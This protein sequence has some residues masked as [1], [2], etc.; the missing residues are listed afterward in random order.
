MDDIDRMLLMAK[1]DGLHMRQLQMLMALREPH[2][3][4]ELARILEIGS[5][6]VKAS[7]DPISMYVKITEVEHKRRMPWKIYSLN[8]KGLRYVAKLLG[9]LR[10]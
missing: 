9:S 5:E 8:K 2:Y 7:L 10:C 6:N 3:A 4:V 1:K